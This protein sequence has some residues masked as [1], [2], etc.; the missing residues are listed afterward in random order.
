MECN[1]ELDV[2]KAVLEGAMAVFN[3]NSVANYFQC[4][5]YEKTTKDN[6]GRTVHVIPTMEFDIKQNLDLW[7]I[8]ARLA[9]N[10]HYQ[11]CQYNMESNEWSWDGQNCIIDFKFRNEVTPEAPSFSWFDYPLT[12]ASR[13]LGG[14]YNEPVWHYQGVD[15]LCKYSNTAMAIRILDE[16]LD[17]KNNSRLIE[18]L[19]AIFDKAKLSLD[20]M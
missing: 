1:L 6:Q 5:A 18:L 19:E 8:K 9:F 17:S 14:S 13:R 20:R 4:K 15:G 2:E 12:F 3:A 7:A 10:V 16:M 11:G